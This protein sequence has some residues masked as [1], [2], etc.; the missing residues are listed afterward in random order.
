MTSSTLLSNCPRC[1]SVPEE[2]HSYTIAVYCPDCYDG[3]PD[4]GPQLLAFGF[5]WQDVVDDW[6]DQAEEFM[7]ENSE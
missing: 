2:D 4:A 5:Q 7:M 6:N 1:G 3:A